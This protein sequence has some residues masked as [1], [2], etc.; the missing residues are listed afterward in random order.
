MLDNFRC[1]ASFHTCHLNVEWYL[2][3]AEIEPL[4]LKLILRGAKEP[5]NFL[6]LKYGNRGTYGWDVITCAACVV[7][8]IGTHMYE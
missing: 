4:I 7:H 8:G 3:R 1:E 6:T 2:D 5:Y